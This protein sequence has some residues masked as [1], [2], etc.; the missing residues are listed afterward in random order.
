MSDQHYHQY[1]FA[2]S[3]CAVNQIGPGVDPRFNVELV[4]HGPITAVASRVGL[5]QFDVKRL[6]GETAEDIRWLKQVAVRH[7]EI[8]CLAAA[9][10]P[11]LPLRLGTVFQS[12]GSL[13]AA[14]KSYRPTVVEFL[15]ALG[16]QQEWAIKLYLED[17][18]PAA[19]ASHTIPTPARHPPTLKAGTEYLTRKRTQLGRRRESQAE[20]QR[21]IQAVE[22][23]LLPR[24]GHC[25]RVR[26][27]PAGLT[28]RRENMVYH[29]AV[30][31][32]PSETRTWLATVGRIRETV[33]N[34][35][36]LLEVSGPWP[37]YHFCPTLEL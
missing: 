27:L 32:A 34:Q 23:Q 26:P 14:M 33:R 22:S 30:L 20:L 15:Y 12:Q 6:Q 37:P 36:L 8:I 16:D 28:G 19:A 25:C 5:D 31:L 13:L 29:A 11:V 18:R 21:E 24:T 1:A 2:L 10:S 9:S 17:R 4:G 7:N 35:G 3:G